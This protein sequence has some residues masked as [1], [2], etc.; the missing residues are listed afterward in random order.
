MGRKNAH[1]YHYADDLS[2]LDENVSKMN[3]FLEVLRVQGAKI[4]SK[5]DISKTKSLRLGISEDEKATLGE[6]FFLI[7]EKLII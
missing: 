6:S 7:C 3:E 2:I 4:C 5:I 1:H